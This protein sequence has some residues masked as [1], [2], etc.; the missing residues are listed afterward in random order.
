MYIKN[1]FRIKDWPI[2]EF[3]K[4]IIIVQFLYLIL[5][6]LSYNGLPIQ[7]FTDVIGFFLILL[8]P[9]VIL[10]RFMNL[11]RLES[12]GQ[13]FLLTVGLS[14]VSLML[15]GFLMNLLY[16]LLGINKPLSS[17]SILFTIN[18]FILFTCLILY[19]I[20]RGRVYHRISGTLN[21][22]VLRKSPPH[23]I[24][25]K[26]L[27]TPT[28]L[29]PFLLP[30]LSIIGAYAMNVYNFNGV[31]ILMILLIGI[32]TFLVSVGRFPPKFYP[33]IILLISI[34][35]LLHKSLITSYIWG[36]DINYEY[37]LANQVISNSIWNEN[38]PVSYN[39]M[40]SVMILAP[41]LNSFINCGLVWIMKVV[42]PF[43]FSL[44]PVGLY[45]VFRKQ[46]SPKIAFLSVFFFII[47]FTFYT[48]M[49]ALLRQQVAELMLVLVLM[50]TI[51]APLNIR[52]RSLLVV[53]FGMSII[54]A[55][56]GLAS[57]MMIIL[58]LSLILIYISEKEPLNRFKNY[59]LRLA[60]HSRVMSLI[61]FFSGYFLG[62][63]KTQK[64]RPQHQPRV[65][66]KIEK[67]R[68]MEK[69]GV[70]TSS[71]IV[72]LILFLLTWYIYTSNST[73]FESL[74]DIVRNIAEN[75]Y[76]FM[77]PNTTQGL[78]LMMAEQ[79][80]PLRNLH[81]YLYLSSQFF[82]GIGIITLILGKDGMNF[83]R[84]YKALSLATFLV[85]VGGVMVPFFSSQMNTTR[86][87]HV[88]LIILAPYCVVGMLTLLNLLKKILRRNFSRKA[89][90]KVISIYFILLLL[91][92]TGLVYQALDKEH[93]SSIALNSSYDFPKFNQYELSG[94]NWL[95]DN[96]HQQTIYADKYRATVLGSVVPC[97]EIPPYFDLVASQSFIFL[98]TGN[99][100]RGKILVYTMAGSNIVQQEGYVSSQEILR[101]RSKVYD[102]GGSNIYSEVSPT[103]I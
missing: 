21:E 33:L 98:G 46:T 82:I 59:W 65:S 39:S 26:K 101:S 28:F 20:N 32:L 52:N 4:L 16:P 94:A 43:I 72:L 80:T 13:I 56:Y 22:M 23:S 8:V 69:R 34:S 48:E 58:I 25:L 45:Y 86:L 51:S 55:H 70:I 100:D 27:A 41:I 18:L 91:F 99:L 75:L 1:P 73:I 57:I 63:N 92:D 50:V 36:W 31:T 19:V 53:I 95:R 37:F 78:N 12:N 17:P 11:G 89:L 49:L 67:Y 3:I 40:L 84:E 88:A 81:K 2:T 47:Q 14:L 68:S 97:K 35:L 61:L 83:N 24:S 15:I 79:T 29:F 42:Y 44:V 90:L 87:Y 76:S 60:Q 10:I 93:P 5:T 103:A 85:L 71:F 77:D 9:G 7:L 96:S 38:L 62:V 74:V 30:I 54:V 66:E 64:I 102:N 6:F